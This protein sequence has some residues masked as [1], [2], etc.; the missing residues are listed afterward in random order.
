[1]QN[2]MFF[3]GKNKGCSWLIIQVKTKYQSGIYRSEAT[4]TAHLLQFI[5]M[6]GNVLHKW[7]CR[8]TVVVFCFFVLHCRGSVCR[9]DCKLVSA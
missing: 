1:M 4:L 7:F 2:L 8:E 9:F 5:S 3:R 6:I